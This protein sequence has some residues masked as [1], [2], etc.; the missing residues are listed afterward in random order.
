MPFLLTYIDVRTVKVFQPVAVCGLFNSNQSHKPY[1][2][3]FFNQI[4]KWKPSLFDYGDNAQFKRYLFILIPLQLSTNQCSVLRLL[5]FSNGYIF[6]DDEDDRNKNGFSGQLPDGSYDRDTLI[7]YCCRDD[8]YATNAIYL[9]TDTPFVLLKSGTHL[10][11]YVHGA[12]MRE[13]FFYWDNEDDFP[14]SEA[15]G[16]HPFLKFDDSNNLKVHYCYYR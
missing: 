11:Q 4:F 10:C 8:G 12:K 13:E 7:Y 6:W 15:K 1:P 16:K 3:S 9:P 2:R 5:G 14:R